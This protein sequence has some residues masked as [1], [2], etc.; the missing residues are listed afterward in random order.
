MKAKMTAEEKTLRAEERRKKQQELDVKYPPGSIGY[1]DS[2]SLWLSIRSGEEFIR[3]FHQPGAVLDV[4]DKAERVQ[5]GCCYLD[6]LQTLG[7]F[8]HALAARYNAF[9]KELNQT[10]S[11]IHLESIEEVKAK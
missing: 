8:I 11:T 10:A 7:S 6:N 5:I 2:F 4:A 1:E 9:A 3:V